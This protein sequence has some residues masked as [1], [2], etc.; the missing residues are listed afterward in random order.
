MILILPLETFPFFR[1]SSM[2]RRVN[3]SR[4]IFPF[5]EST[6]DYRKPKEFEG[7]LP[8]ELLRALGPNNDL[9]RLL[10]DELGTIYNHIYSAYDHMQ[11]RKRQEAAFEARLQRLENLFGRLLTR[12]A[13]EQPDDYEKE[14]PY[15]DGCGQHFDDI[16]D[17][18]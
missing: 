14:F 18:R 5:G 13:I 16:I 8:L 10:D 1:R 6:M 9:E 12:L 15:W 17:W 4:E 11:D 7:H 2:L 3:A